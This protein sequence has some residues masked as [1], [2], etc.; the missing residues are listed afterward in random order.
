LAFG[1]V[2]PTP[3]P[4]VELVLPEATAVVVAVDKLTHCELPLTIS[5]ALVVVL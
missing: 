3:I 4:P 1:E 5:S 2:V